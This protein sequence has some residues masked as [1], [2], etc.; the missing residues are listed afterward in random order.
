M[1]V[2]GG[3]DGSIEGERLAKRPIGGWRVT[4][5]GG[6]AAA[7]FQDARRQR[8]ALDRGNQ[9]LGAI[10]RGLDLRARQVPVRREQNLR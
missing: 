5:G 1:G 6:K 10:E 2:T 4:E 7:E 8:V 9:F 3:A